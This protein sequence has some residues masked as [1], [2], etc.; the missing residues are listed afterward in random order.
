MPIG[1]KLLSTIRDASAGVERLPSF[2]CYTQAMNDVPGNDASAVASNGSAKAPADA[3]GGWQRF[4][5]DKGR[6]IAYATTFIA[7]IVLNVQFAFDFGSA[8]L[9]GL[10]MLCIPGCIVL[11]IGL[12][13]FRVYRPAK[14]L[15]SVAVVAI[16]GFVAA[17][18]LNWM[19]RQTTEQTGQS[20]VVALTNYKS[21]KGRYPEQLAD[22]VPAYLSDIP[23]TSMGLIAHP[24]FFY[25]TDETGGEF[26]LVFP[27]PTWMR[28]EY[29]SDKGMWYI[30]D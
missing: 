29:S 25:N 6:L 2:V 4:L 20:I 28:C 8:A 27:C 13:M 14:T 21:A 17:N 12:A 1:V 9:V 23:T 5:P 16:L 30:H 10:S 26:E 15:A 19:K 22:L 18:N 24:E 7:V 11:A 3:R